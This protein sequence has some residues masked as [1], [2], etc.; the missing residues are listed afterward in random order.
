[1]QQQQQ[2]QRQTE[3]QTSRRR[4]ALASI[5]AGETRNQRAVVEATTMSLSH[6]VLHSFPLLNALINN[7]CHSFFIY[8]S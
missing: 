2:Q 1:M 6:F 8:L 3:R 5:E 7:S 4:K